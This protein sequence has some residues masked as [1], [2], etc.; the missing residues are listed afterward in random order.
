MLLTYILPYLFSCVFNMKF[1]IHVAQV[2][3]VSTAIINVRLLFV[4]VVV[5]VVVV[6]I[7]LRML[8]RP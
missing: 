3:P 1:I 6:F 8:S 5:V 7:P 4:V 2:G